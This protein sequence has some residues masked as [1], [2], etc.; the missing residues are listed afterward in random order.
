MRIGGSSHRLISTLQ[1]GH[2]GRGMAI[3]F[4]ST[5]SLVSNDIDAP[6][7]GSV[8]FYRDFIFNISAGPGDVKLM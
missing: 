1:C 5:S 3:T 4:S 7:F 2:L 6:P 8:H